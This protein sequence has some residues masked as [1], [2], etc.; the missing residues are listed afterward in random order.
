VE[1]KPRVEFAL[2]RY[3]QWVKDLEA[4]VGTPSDVVER[5]VAL[6]NDYRRFID[7]DT[8]FD[9][10]QDFLYRQAGQLKLNNSVIEEFLP[11]LVRPDV[12]PEIDGFDVEVGPTTCFSSVY[13]QTS[14]DSVAVGG[15]LNVRAKDQDFAISRRLFL[16]AA[17]DSNFDDAV[18]KSTSIAYVVAE[19]KTNLD[20]TMFQEACATAHDVKAAVSGAR[21][22]L[23]CEWLDM[24]PLSTAPTDIDEVLILRMS[25]RVNSNVR[26]KY[27]SYEGR[28]RGRSAYLKYLDAH[29]FQRE[30]FDRFLHHIRG[31]LRNDAPV[32]H[33]VLSRGYF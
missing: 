12:L 7:V 11:W 13:F 32:E 20:K 3:R 22:Y 16:R 27:G 24:A 25:K 17:H 30:M 31:L 33:E 6:L 15:G 5:M 18:T 19:C 26:N 21:Y 29:P 2:D 4:V 28:R 1:D 23:L 8:I 14:L 9:S 10:R